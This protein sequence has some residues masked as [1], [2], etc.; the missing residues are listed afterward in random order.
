MKAKDVLKTLQITRPTLTKYVKE[1]KVRVKDL[2]NGR[3]D[4][5]KE[6]VYNLINKGVQRK[7]YIYTKVNEKTELDRCIE[8]LKEFSFARGYTVSKVFSD[9]YALLDEVQAGQVERVVASSK[10]DFKDYELV[11]YI[12]SKNN[13]QLVLMSELD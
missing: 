7:T 12:I 11:D 13:C 3:Y 9:L 2:G 1:G 6:S 8:Q 10:A 5:D 4:Y